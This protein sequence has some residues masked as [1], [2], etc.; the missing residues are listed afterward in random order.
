MIK[1]TSTIH[2]HQEAQ[3][4]RPT[5]SN[6]KCISTPHETNREDIRRHGTLIYPSTPTGRTSIPTLNPQ[7]RGKKAT[8]ARKQCS[9]TPSGKEIV[10]G[11]KVCMSG[12]A[13]IDVLHRTLAGCDPRGRSAEKTRQ[14][15]PV[16]S[17]LRT[18]RLAG[19]SLEGR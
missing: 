14:G 2:L 10:A 11:M 13:S 19:Q 7:T 1:S 17:A 12:T 15:H 5:R 9:E 3:R 8:S 16:V 4:R 18:L 6:A